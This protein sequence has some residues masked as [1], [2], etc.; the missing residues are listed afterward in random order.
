MAFARSEFAD[1]TRLSGGRRYI[2]GLHID[3]PLLLS[4]LLLAGIGLV[5][6]YSASE[7]SNDVV[8]KQLIR[9]TIAFGIMFAVAQ[10]SPDTIEH[11]SPWL[12]G[13]G[14]VM[15]VAVLLLGEV[16][17]GA[18]RW[19]DLGLF[20]FQPSELMKLALP[21]IIAWYLSDTT[22]P[23]R[24]SRIIIS[25]ALILLPTFLVARQP[26][27]GTAILLAGSGIFVLFLA[28]LR[29]RFIITSFILL[30]PLS[31]VLWQYGMHDYQRKRVLTFL[32]PESDPL[33]SGYHIIQSTIAI[34]SVGL[35]GKGWRD[36]TQ[37]LLY[38]LP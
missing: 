35:N 9:L 23:P 17:K 33:G 36:G 2:R 6:L 3:L 15:L 34:G 20:T 29:W 14:L 18:K 24:F 21:M 22:L 4:L 31:W 11:W 32:N 27:L 37:S 30:I 19:L 25:L 8:I 10:L 1:T 13:V 28:G 16:G 7:Q 12:F 26:D 38:F 5:V